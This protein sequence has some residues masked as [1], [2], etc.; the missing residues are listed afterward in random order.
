MER[1]RLLD[2]VLSACFITVVAFSR[3]V[4]F[5][6]TGGLELAGKQLE[7]VCLF[8]TCTKS[9]CPFCGLSGSMVALA[10]GEI[11]LSFTC[12]VLGPF[13][14]LVFV[15]FVIAAAISACGAGRP[16][17]ETRVFSRSLL[18]IV[19]ASLTLW[20]IQSVCSLQYHNR[21]EWR[22]PG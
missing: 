4:N 2:G 21:T 9:P 18:L 5:S 15:A 22:V 10:H 19:V 16:I 12:N 13:V 17:I 1:A 7:R 6:P 20:A 14:S 11:R 3:V 8:Q